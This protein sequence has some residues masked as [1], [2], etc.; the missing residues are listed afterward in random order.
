MGPEGARRERV[1]VM[2]TSSRFMRGGEMVKGIGWVAWS[3]GL[4]PWTEVDGP[5]MALFPRLLATI[6][7]STNVV[8]FG[9]SHF[10][11]CLAHRE[12]IGLVSSSR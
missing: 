2:Q 6:R 10:S 7:A 1:N 8:S 4:G 12:H 5:G 3:G 9:P 11:P